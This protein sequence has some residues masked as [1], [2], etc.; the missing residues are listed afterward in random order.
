[1][2]EGALLFSPLFL[3]LLAHGLCMRFGWLGGLAR[4]IDRGRTWRGRRLFGENKTYRGIVA[5]AAGTALGFALLAGNGR[6]GP[7]LGSRPA[8][9]LLGLAVG[10]A[11]MLAELPNSLLKRQLDVA[12]GSQ[13]AGLRGALFHVLDQVDVLAG[14]WLVLA[15]AVP[16][17]AARALGSFIFIYMGHQ[18]ATLV[19]YALGLRGTAR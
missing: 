3:G 2:A 1:V 14:G 15:W 8:A 4:P 12:P 17:T 19:G 18:L 11:A 5:V 13:A 9:L 16:L 6:V 7:M 10:A